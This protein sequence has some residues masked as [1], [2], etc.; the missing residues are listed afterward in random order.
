VLQQYAG[1]NADAAESLDDEEWSAQRKLML[2][3]QSTNKT[4]RSY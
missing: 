3:E 4:Q 2:E 1:Q